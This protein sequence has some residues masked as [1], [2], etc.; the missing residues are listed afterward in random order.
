[1]TPAKVCLAA[2]A[3]GKAETKIA[4]RCRELGITSQTLDSSASPTGE[5]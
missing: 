1:M 5:L 4:D 2:A 3:M